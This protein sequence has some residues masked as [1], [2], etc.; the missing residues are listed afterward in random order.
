MKQSEIVR[1]NAENCVRL[2]EA[3]TNEPLHLQANGSWVAGFGQRA[4][5]A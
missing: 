5:F 4:R 2:A 3:A 1:E